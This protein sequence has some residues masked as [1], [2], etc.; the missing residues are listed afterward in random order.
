MSCNNSLS[1]PCRALETSDGISS[2]GIK[3]GW[4]HT[5]SFV[6]NSSLMVR[7]RNLSDKEQENIEK[8][9][10]SHHKPRLNGTGSGRY[11]GP[12][13]SITNEES[14]DTDYNLNLYEDVVF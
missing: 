7:K 5:T 2:V 4:N 12:K 3:L 13:I 6:S 11:K 14:D 1:I 9:L 10:I 8:A